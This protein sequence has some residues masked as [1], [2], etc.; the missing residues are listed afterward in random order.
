MRRS[1]TRRSTVLDPQTAYSRRLAA[2]KAAIKPNATF[3]S[4]R[5]AAN[6]S[7][8][9]HSLSRAAFT[10]CLRAL[11]YSWT[12]ESSRLKRDGI[13]SFGGRRY[14]QRLWLRK[15]QRRRGQANAIVDQ[16]RRMSPARVN[17]ER[18]AEL[19]KRLTEVTNAE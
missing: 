15:W 13:P 9:G 7:A 19:R 16:L 10:D 8:A 6:A 14:V 18:R 11:G 17:D 5:A 4:A 2:I 12:G 1:D 3:R